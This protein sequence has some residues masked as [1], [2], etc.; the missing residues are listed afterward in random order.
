MGMQCLLTYKMTKHFFWVK[1]Q[2]CFEKNDRN[3]SGTMPYLN[4]MSNMK[5]TLYITK[6]REY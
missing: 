4:T 5:M 1:D 3:L 6:S 2:L